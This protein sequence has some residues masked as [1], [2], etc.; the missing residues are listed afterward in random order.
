[1]SGISEE[2]L[3]LIERCYE[4]A[5]FSVRHGHVTKQPHGCVAKCGGPALCKS[6]MQE[7]AGLAAAEIRRQSELIDGLRPLA[8]LG[9]DAARQDGGDFESMEIY[10]S[11]IRHGVLVEVPFDRSEHDDPHGECGEGDQWAEYPPLV[12]A[13]KRALEE[14]A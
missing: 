3:Q 11:A 8:R 10:E 12:L 14:E 2:H 1:M 6:C 7:L 5:Q 4:I 9:M 13:A